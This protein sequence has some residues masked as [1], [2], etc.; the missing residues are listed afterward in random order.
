MHEW[1][2]RWL[3]EQWQEWQSRTRVS[4]IESL[5]RF[6]TI[7]IEHRAKTPEGLRAYL[8]TALAHGSDRDAQ[9]EKWMAKNSL[10]LGDLDRERIVDI[11][12]RFGL[13][14]DGSPMAANTTNR[15]RII[16]REVARTKRSADVRALP[17]PAAMAEAIDAILTQQ[18]DSK[19]HRV[20]TPARLF[21]HVA[22]GADRREVS[23]F[24]CVWPTRSLP[25][26]VC[27]TPPELFLDP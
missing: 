3:A 9:H 16:A 14:L 11:D 26:R 27:A 22:P 10:T 12:R 6:I 21:A 13:K 5:A 15:I 8:Y 20:K 23:E 19:P 17:S 24:R 25:D 2:R 4:A 18:P 7:A 1:S